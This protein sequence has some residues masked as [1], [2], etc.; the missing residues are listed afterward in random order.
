MTEPQTGQIRQ[1]IVVGVDGSPSSVEALLWADYLAKQLDADIEAITSWRDPI[2]WNDDGW[3]DDTGPRQEAVRQQ[4]SALQI[5]FGPDRPARLIESIVWDSP[6]AA[7][8][9]ASK[10]A[11]MVLL[12]SRGHGG[13]AGVLLGSVSSAVAEKAACPV[14]V[15]HGHTVPS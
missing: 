2:G 15:V 4:Q 1:R 13:L 14:L 8:I 10:T 7:L 12:G 6:T 9:T 11:T 3:V 5:A